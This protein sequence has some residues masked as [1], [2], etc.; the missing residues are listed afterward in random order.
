MQIQ[1]AEDVRAFVV[2]TFLFG[3]GDEL[4][5]N[6]SFLEQGIIDSTGVLE[7]ISWVE[8]RYG[9]EVGDSELLPDNFDSI[10]KV[11]AYLVTKL[12]GKA[13]APVPAEV[14]LQE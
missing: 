14:V 6:D 7:L 1:F 4:R 9:I 5:D 8:E 2:S 3:K 13:E 12:D 10:E 11:A